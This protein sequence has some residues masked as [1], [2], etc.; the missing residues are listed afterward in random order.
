M[1]DTRIRAFSEVEPDTDG[2]RPPAFIDDGVVSLMNEESYW[3]GSQQWIEI[4][5]EHCWP[6]EDWR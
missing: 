3:I 6:E 1:S 2:D 4:D 5:K